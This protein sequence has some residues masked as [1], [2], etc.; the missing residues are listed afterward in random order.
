[1]RA[2]NS[3]TVQAVKVSLTRRRHPGLRRKEALLWS[4]EALLWSKEA[5]LWRKEALLWSI[6]GLLSGSGRGDRAFPLKN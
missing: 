6:P 5:L 4:K 1:M 2:S 3:A